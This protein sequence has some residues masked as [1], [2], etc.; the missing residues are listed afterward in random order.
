MDFFSAPDET[1]PAPQQDVGPIE[2]IEII[3]PEESS[4]PVIFLNFPIYDYSVLS[5][6][7]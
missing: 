4:P 3:A 2:E 6:I 1:T 5:C 7:F